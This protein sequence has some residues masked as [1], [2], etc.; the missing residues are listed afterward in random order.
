MDKNLIFFISIKVCFFLYYY[1]FCRM[2]INFEF[3][4]EEYKDFNILKM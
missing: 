2:K 4:Y 1:L 3:C